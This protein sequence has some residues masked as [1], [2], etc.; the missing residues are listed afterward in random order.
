MQTGSSVTGDQHPPLPMPLEEQLCFALYVASRAS[1]GRYRRVLAELGLTYPQYLVMH[2]LW[3]RGP[4]SMGELAVALRL[5]SGTLS[6]LVKRLASSGFVDRQ[7]NPQDERRVEV[8]CTE[9]GDDLRRA[10]QG[11]FVDFRDELDVSGGEFE[12]LVHSL[13]ALAERYG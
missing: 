2:V 1:V 6:P 12:A 13:H 9:A 3:E 4:V 11:I 5:D 10:A 7:R 8:F